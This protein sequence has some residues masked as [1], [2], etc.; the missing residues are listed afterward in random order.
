[1]FCVYLFFIVKFPHTSTLMTLLWVGYRTLG[2]LF[3]FF[4]GW[5]NDMVM[6]F[7]VVVV[8][9]QI[10]FPTRPSVCVVWWSVRCHL[11]VFHQPTVTLPSPLASY[12]RQ[13]TIFCFISCNF[14]W[15]SPLGFTSSPFFEIIVI[16]MLDCHWDMSRGLVLF[17]LLQSCLRLPV[18]PSRVGKG[19]SGA[20]YSN[21]FY[22]Q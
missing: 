21:G 5:A 9:Q 18:G 10:L 11:E 2:F 22:P 19:C 12:S 1:M 15:N 7:T 20:N 8:K 13:W 16:V 14:I 17:Q 6:T 3:F 4:A